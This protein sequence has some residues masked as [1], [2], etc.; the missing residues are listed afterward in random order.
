MKSGSA[1]LQGNTEMKKNR[2]L[3]NPNWKHWETNIINAKPVCFVLFYL[4]SPA[5]KQFFEPEQRDLLGS[6]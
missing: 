4:N 5:F 1:R 2:N 3:F 6:V